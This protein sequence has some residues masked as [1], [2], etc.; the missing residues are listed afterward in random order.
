[1]ANVDPMDNNK[2]TT[3]LKS[4]G[5]EYDRSIRTLYSAQSP[6]WRP[7]K[8][9]Y[10]F[11]GLAGGQRGNPE[12]A[13][14]ASLFAYYFNPRQWLRE[15]IHRRLQNS[16]PSDLDPERTIGVPIRRSDKCQ[17]HN[18]E[19]SAKGEM[20]CHPL[21]TYRKGVETFLK[22]DPAIENLIITSE[23]AAACAE[24]V[25]MMKK[26]HPSLRIVLN[27]GDVQQGTGSG[28]KLESYTEG[29]TNADVVAR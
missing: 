9:V 21:E 28:S 20:Q 1:M 3:V 17:G 27:V 11:T 23:D 15:E 13:M 18:I 8:D 5:D 26:E 4:H 19:G 2:T 7:I 10:A 14:V 16:I 29:A 6:W 24:F 12:L 25:E 22:F